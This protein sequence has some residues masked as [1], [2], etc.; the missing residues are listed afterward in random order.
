MLQ[1]FGVGGD[2]AVEVAQDPSAVAA[3]EQR[4]T[5]EAHALR[6]RRRGPRRSRATSAWSSSLHGLARTGT[7]GDWAPQHLDDELLEGTV[8]E[9][10]DGEWADAQLLF[11]VLHRLHAEHLLEQVGQRAIGEALEPCGGGIALDRRRHCNAI[12]IAVEATECST[13][14]CTQHRSARYDDSVVGVDQVVGSRGCGRQQG[15]QA[16]LL[17]GG[18]VDDRPQAGVERRDMA[19]PRRLALEEIVGPPPLAGQLGGDVEHPP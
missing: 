13:S 2:E 17:L 15:A 19:Q 11:R 14:T 5:G 10:A 8:E 18:R 7:L 4:T 9:V 1:P 3:P 16:V 6:T 12:D